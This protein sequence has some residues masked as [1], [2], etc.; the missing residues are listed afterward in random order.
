M[1]D[2]DRNERRDLFAAMA[3]PDV[4]EWFKCPLP[5]LPAPIFPDG[6]GEYCTNSAEIDAA[7]RRRQEIRFFAWHRFFAV[8]LIEELDAPAG[9]AK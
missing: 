7:R 6:P 9:G 2:D 3:P 8:R 4:P 1:D 5:E